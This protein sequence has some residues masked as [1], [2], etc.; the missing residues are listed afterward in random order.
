MVAEG[1]VIESELVK[2]MGNVA[3]VLVRRGSLKNGDVIVAG[4][5]FCKIRG[6]KD[7]KGKIVKLAG[8]STPVQVWGWKELPDSGDH[9]IQAKLEQIAKKVIDFRIARAQQIQASRDIEDINIKRAEEIKEAERLE[10]IAELKKAGLDSSELEREAQDTKITKC[11]YIIKSDVFGSAEAIKESIHEL[12]NDEVQSCV[13]SHSAGAPTDSDL[14]MAKTFNATIFCF[15]I[16]PPKQ[17]VQRAEREKINIV[18]HN[19]IYRLIEQVTDELNSHLKPRIETKILG[20]VD[21]KDIFTITQGKSKIKVAGCKVAT[22][23]IKR[24]SDVKVLRGDKEVFKGTLS[25]LKHVKDDIS[26]A[27]KGNECGLGFHNW[28]GFEAGDKILVYEEIEHKR[29]L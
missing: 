7:E 15:N 5:T 11:N 17:I 3:T 29:Y 27:R 6:M 24:S 20:E 22:G 19:I 23:V 28:T 9:I 1:W 2:G 25:S 10:K 12:G 18:E 21:I 8:P 13:I 26:E 16:K 14:D 4:E